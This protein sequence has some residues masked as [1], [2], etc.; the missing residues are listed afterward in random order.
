LSRAGPCRR[1]A[2]PL[3]LAGLAGTALY[4]AH[5]VIA[6]G[7]AYEAKT[8]CSGVFVSG[9]GPEAVLAEDV[10]ADDLAFLRHFDATVDRARGLSRAG[11][12]GGLV[13]RQAVY[14]PGLGCTLVHDGRPAIPAGLELPEPAP[15]PAGPP[16][17]MIAD[18]APGE[19]AR[20]DAVLDWAFAE[21]DP[22]RPR[23]TRAV[24]ILGDRG[25]L[26]ERYAEGFGPETPLPG[27]SMA[28][29][30]VNALVGILVQEGKLGLDRP[31]A[32]PE[33]QAPADPRGR[34]TV[35][36]LLTMTSGLE[37]GEIYGNPLQDVTRMLLDRPDAAAYAADKELAAEPGTAWAYSSGTT[38][39]LSRTLRRTLGDAAYR[40]FPRRALF[41]PLGMDGAVFEP[42]ASGTF[43]GSSFLYATARDWARFGRLY[44]RDGLW[45]GRRLLPEGWVGYSTT[46]VPQAPEGQ[47]GAHF[48]LKLPEIYRTPGDI[49]PLPQDAFHAVGHE[50]QFV[51]VIPSRRLVVV[52]LGLS[53]Q[54]HSWAQDAFLSRILEAL[55]P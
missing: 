32:A 51:S 20:L 43:V 33:W 12:L 37:F 42:D 31:V 19:R 10:A 54:P 39:L 1:R 41:G 16:D 29:S 8:L 3:V 30:V 52:R 38:N 48:W 18:L 2:L 35:G 55:Q 23:R 25:I 47:Y 11:F 21:P 7:L 4:Y 15:A 44:L 9:R 40:D 28:K 26:A 5:S 45:E 34:I 50:G 6:I 49:L 27:W 17:R 13:E 14:R 53:R 46:P 36:Q 22:E 24:V